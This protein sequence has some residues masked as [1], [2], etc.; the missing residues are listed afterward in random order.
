MT[1]KNK[2]EKGKSDVW[3]QFFA[4]LNL[5]RTEESPHSDDETKQRKWQNVVG[6]YLRAVFQAERRNALRPWIKSLSAFLQEEKT[7]IPVALDQ[8]E[9]GRRRVGY[10]SKKHK[11]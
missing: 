10:N 7:S 8:R 3:E 9:R 6:E 4:N 1:E 2:S 5:M 11:N